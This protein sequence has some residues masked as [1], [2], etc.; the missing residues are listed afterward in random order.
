[1]AARRARRALLFPGCADIP[2]L[3][4]LSLSLLLLSPLA[5]VMAANGGG[6]GRGEDVSSFV[7][8]LVPEAAP[9]LMLQEFLGPF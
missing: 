5:Q 3:S 7:S 2:S 1:M 8:N 6:L 4:L 9:G